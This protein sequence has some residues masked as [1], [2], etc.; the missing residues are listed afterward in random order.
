MKTT[1]LT[2]ARNTKDKTKL[3]ELSTK[4]LETKLLNL[5]KSKN[6]ETQKD[7]INTAHNMGISVLL[8]VVHS[9]A[10]TNIGEGLYLQDGTEDQYFLSG[11]RGWHE[12]WKT[13]C[14]DYGKDE[15]LHLF[16]LQE[17]YLKV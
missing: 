14:F 7:L 10:C 12:A 16:L 6:V 15:V 9:H 3:L 5:F 1:S 13:K 8:D 4:V 17:E 11:K 2:L